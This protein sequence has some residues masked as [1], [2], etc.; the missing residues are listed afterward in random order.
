[1]KLQYVN[2]NNYYIGCFINIDKNYLEKTL[3]KK[4]D[5]LMAKSTCNNYK[6]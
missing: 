1:M 5:D 6:N 4:F 2:Y 3:F